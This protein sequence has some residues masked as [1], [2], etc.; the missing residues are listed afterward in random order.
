[1]TKWRSATSRRLASSFPSGI[2]CG[3]TAPNLEETKRVLRRLSLTVV[4]TSTAILVPISPADATA[5]VTYS[6]SDLGVVSGWA[7]VE[8]V[9]LSSDGSAI[10]VEL[11]RSTQP[12][13]AAG[14]VESG[15]MNTVP[16]PSDLTLAGG[17]N[18]SGVLVGE[19]F[20]SWPNG[21]GSKAFMYESGSV[22]FLQSLGGSRSAAYAI[23]DSGLIV[24]TSIPS[25]AGFGT[26]A[27]WEGSTPSRLG[28]LYGLNGES[29]AYAVD[30]SGQAAGMS[31]LT[32]TTSITHAVLFA[33]GTV[34][35]LTPTADLGTQLSSAAYGMNDEGQVVGAIG[36]SSGCS[37]P[38]TCREE[39]FLASDGVFGGTNLLSLGWTAAAWDINDAWE[40]VGSGIV[41]ADPLNRHGFV[42]LNGQVHDLNDILDG[43][44]S[45]WTVIDASAIDNQGDIVGTARADSDGSIHAVLLTPLAPA[46]L[47]TTPPGGSI[48]LDSGAPTTT[49][50][51]VSV[52]PTA[53]D[54]SGVFEVRISNDAS[55]DSSGG[56]I[57]GQSFKPNQD[58]VWS[59]INRATGGSTTGGMRSVYAQWRDWAGNWSIPTSEDIGFDPT[60]VDSFSVTPSPFFPKPHDGVLDAATIAWQTDRTAADE[61]VIKNSNGRVIRKF[62]PGLLDATPHSIRWRG[63]RSDGTWAPPGRYTIV[64]RAS[65][66]GYRVRSVELGVRLRWGTPAT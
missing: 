14:L 3:A 22:S 59:L 51:T 24:G 12:S 48:T 26:A 23:N 64:V 44:G 38:G 32:A 54:A 56:L 61:I 58:V 37:S 53:T 29:G 18:S 10:A 16:T 33:G 60:S 63:R 15:S 66:D 41:N 13:G 7:G 47:D 17:V 2:I 20:P 1:M 31:Q 11:S 25:G 39:A 62:A 27:E 5:P 52:H 8:G 57:D 36:G 45:G 46:T 43:S 50:P 28:S 34:V 30:S 21:S 55:V 19:D 6:L 40:I 4:L 65:A 35:D 49:H 42:E 9:G